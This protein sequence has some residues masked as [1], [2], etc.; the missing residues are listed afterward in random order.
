MALWSEPRRA[1]GRTDGP[2]TVAEQMDKTC[3]ARLLLP[4]IECKYQGLALSLSLSLCVCVSLSLSISL[5][6]RDSEY[7][8]CAR[9]PFFRKAAREFSSKRR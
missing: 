4:P 7:K 8:H 1:E 9:A 3:K 2:R 5:P 6:P